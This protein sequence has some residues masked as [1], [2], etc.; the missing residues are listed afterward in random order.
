MNSVQERVI[1][2]RKDTKKEVSSMYKEAK[3][4]KAA[5]PTE[6]VSLFA[7]RT[8]A[9][10]EEDFDLE[11][12]P[13]LAKR[14]EE[15]A[16]IERLP[17]NSKIML[18]ALS[19]FRA[20]LNRNPAPKS[21]DAQATGI[22]ILRAELDS[23]IDGMFNA[24]MISGNPVAVQRWKDARSAYAEYARTFKDN[25]VVNQLATQVANWIF[26]ASAVGAKKQSAAVVA[27]L[28]QILGKDSPEFSAIRQEAV[29][30]VVEPLLR[31]TPDFKAFGKNYERMA[32]SNPT[33]LK[34]L[35]EDSRPA[36]ETLYKHSQA[37]QKSAGAKINFDLNQALSQAAFGHSIARAGLKVRLAK[38]AIAL[39]RRSV[40]GS[41]KRRVMSE[42]LGYDVG[43]TAIPPE[44]L[45]YSGSVAAERE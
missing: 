31:D 3:K 8:R 27:K 32:R 10:L 2:A 34:E 14:V 36:M 15:L 33:L 25:R 21:D 17:R 39:I 22:G 24:D 5:V 30:D 38:T 20:R 42:L 43:A 29:F 7:R 41:D 13:R 45:L 19:A 6:A 44:A 9:K 18:S 35:F 40:E 37:L 1:Q 28:K 12:M 26:G 4:T 16:A 11:D 23:F